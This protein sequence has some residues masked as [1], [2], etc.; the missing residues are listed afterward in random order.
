MEYLNVIKTQELFNYED[1]RAQLKPVWS[2]KIQK[3]E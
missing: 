2:N 3:A 1:I